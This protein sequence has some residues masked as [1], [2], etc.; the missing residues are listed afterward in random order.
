MMR[1]RTG[2]IRTYCHPPGMLPTDPPAKRA[3]DWGRLARIEGE[4]PQPEDHP[5]YEGDYAHG[6]EGGRR[7]RRHR[8]PRRIRHWIRRAFVPEK[9][10]HQ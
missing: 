3:F 1:R 5:G 6:Y 2:E 10:N 8:R 4:P 9:G 7:Q